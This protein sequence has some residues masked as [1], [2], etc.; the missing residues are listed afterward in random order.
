[1]P[2]DIDI[3]IPISHFEWTALPGFPGIQVR[4]LSSNFDEAKRTGRRTRLV[5][6]EPGTATSRP[7]VHDYHEETFLISGDVEGFGENA[8][9]G[10]FN[11]QAYV[12]RLPGTPHGPIR[13]IGG[14]VLLEIQYYAD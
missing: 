13:S 9:F 1:M 10:A 8:A 11:E 14:C 3:F 6:F 4:H 5:R 12:H 2:N 7:L